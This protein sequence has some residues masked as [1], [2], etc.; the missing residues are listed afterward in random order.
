MTMRPTRREILQLLDYSYWL[1]ASLNRHIL[2]FYFKLT[3]EQVT[4]VFSFQCDMMCWTDLLC[5]SF[6]QLSMKKFLA[7]DFNVRTHHMHD[8]MLKWIITWH[9]GSQLWADKPRLST[10]NQ[11]E[12]KSLM[13]RE[14]PAW[15]VP[16][17]LPSCTEP[18]GGR[19]PPTL[20]LL[21]LPQGKAVTAAAKPRRN[22][23]RPGRRWV[24]CDPFCLCDLSVLRSQL[25]GHMFL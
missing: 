11:C 5:H 6:I 22:L 8:K 23:R 18:R 16:Y 20:L 7:A 2:T 24:N 19:G 21:L 12:Q 13:W 15:S 4:S 3:V 14:C 9:N 17:D 1:S 10:D 25:N